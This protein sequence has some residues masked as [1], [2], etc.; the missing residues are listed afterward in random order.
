MPYSIELLA[1]LW[2]MGEAKEGR[3]RYSPWQLNPPD[4]GD[5][6]FS[7]PLPSGVRLM[8]CRPSEDD[9]LY[10]KTWTSSAAF[11]HER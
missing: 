1:A 7:P 5:M 3:E 8:L 2:R 6:N 9:L 11:R 10:R 4:C